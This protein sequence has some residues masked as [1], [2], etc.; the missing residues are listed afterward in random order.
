MRLLVSNR[1]GPYPALR[2]KKIG[3]FWSARVGGNYRALAIETRDGFVWF[4]HADYDKL[5]G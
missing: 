2:F 5:V 1:I 4:R 3:R